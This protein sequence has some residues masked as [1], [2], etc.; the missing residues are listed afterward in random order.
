MDSLRKNM[1]KSIMGTYG[2]GLDDS[3]KKQV[4]KPNIMQRN[5]AKRKMLLR[6]KMGSYG[7]GGCNCPGKKCICGGQMSAVLEQKIDNFIAGIRGKSAVKGGNKKYK[8][9]GGKEDDDY[10]DDNIPALPSMPHVEE[11][12]KYMG[13][14]KEAADKMR[15]YLV[16][17]KYKSFKKGGNNESSI[18]KNPYMAKVYGQGMR[19]YGVMG[20]RKHVTI[21]ISTRG[22]KSKKAPKK[23]DYK[24][25]R[26]MEKALKIDMEKEERIKEKQKREMDLA[27]RLFDSKS[28]KHT[29]YSYWYGRD[30]SEPNLG[31]P[32][33]DAVIEEK[34]KEDVP[35]YASMAGSSLYMDD[36]DVMGSYN[37][38]GGSKIVLRLLPRAGKK[39]KKLKGGVDSA[40]SKQLLRKAFGKLDANEKKQ[41][42]KY[43]MNKGIN[44][45]KQE[46]KYYSGPMVSSEFEDI[47]DLKEVIEEKGVPTEPVELVIDMKD[48]EDEEDY[49]RLE[50]DLKKL[51]LILDKDSRDLIG[52]IEK[53]LGVTDD[54][55]P[56]SDEPLDKY[57]AKKLLKEC[58]I[59]CE[60]D[61]E[62]KM[63]KKRKLTDYNKFAQYTLTKLS[64]K[65]NKIKK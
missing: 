47:E 37:V 27:R 33:I 10:E 18:K 4:P 30:R 51:G 52:M 59:V 43:K 28:A 12:Q 14:Q 26:K 55:S 23:D 39:Y 58:D 32:G 56:M 19:N 34:L 22:K 20:G 42:I 9:K 8:M 24:K 21:N 17:V 7:K 6:D 64:G 45:Q 16:N 15:D 63:L 25:R 29:W 5:A 50:S 38:R 31:D 2:W 54:T 11:E 57:Q 36:D 41:R 62:K 48:Y 49:D 61:F 1:L 44:L 3:K 40:F 65:T 13:L 53:E 46:Q 60:K 35:Y